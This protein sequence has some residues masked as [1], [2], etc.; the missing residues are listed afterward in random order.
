M[1]T[2]PV[3]ASGEL[4]SSDAAVERWYA[5]YKAATPQVIVQSA[6][7]RYVLQAVEGTAAEAYADT[8]G[9]LPP[10]LPQ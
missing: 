4:V 1:V 9:A 2:D 3:V 7:A 6:S 5:D 8:A 10:S